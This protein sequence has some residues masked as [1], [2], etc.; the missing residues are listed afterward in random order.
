[1]TPATQTLA[2]PQLDLV[3]ERE[4]DLPKEL[5]WQAWT[6]P[7]LIQ[8]WFTP[9]PWQ[10]VGCE[11]DLRP[12]G[13]FYTVMRSPEGQDFP[14]TGCFL[15]VVENQRLVWTSALGPGFRPVPAVPGESATCDFAF[16][17]ILT[18]ASQ[19]TGTRYTALV[20]HRDEADRQK[21]DAMGFQ[22]GWGKAFD[23]LVA[24]VKTL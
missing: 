20:L 7:E 19:G 8:Q 22:D 1:M 3:F 21:H 6:R 10:T 14:N 11:I 12:G 2:N 4:V 13:L 23:Q 16:T 15:E 5:I 24:L 9:A 17:V 18:L